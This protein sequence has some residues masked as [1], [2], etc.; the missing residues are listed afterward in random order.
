MIV[1]WHDPDEMI[2]VHDFDS[3]PNF[4]S[5]GMGPVGDCPAETLMKAPI[6][7][8]MRCDDLEIPIW[9]CEE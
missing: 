1:P 7:F 3:Q 9:W 2:Q 4:F 6:G 8:K 5:G